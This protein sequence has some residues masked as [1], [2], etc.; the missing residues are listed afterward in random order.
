MSDELVE[1]FKKQRPLY[2]A[3]TLSITSLLGQLLS[4]QGIS[5]FSVES[6][7][8]DIESFSRKVTREDKVDKYIILSNITDLSGIRI[9]CY[10]QQDC[11]DIEN[12]INESF[13]VDIENSTSKTNEIDADK[14]GYLSDHYVISITN[15]RAQ[16]PEFARFRSMKAE[17]QV[18]TVL[19]HTW[20]AIDHKLRYKNDANIPRA[21][22]RRLFRISALLESA[23][24]EFSFLNEK[25]ESLR[26]EYSMDIEQGKLNIPINADSVLA[27]LKSSSLIDKMRHIVGHS[28][29]F[30]D[31]DKSLRAD[32]VIDVANKLGVEGVDD[33]VARANRGLLEVSRKWGKLEAA[34]K[35][36]NRIAT[37]TSLL[38]LAVVLGSDEQVRKELLGD[39]NSPAVS[40]FG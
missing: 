37:R 28:D 18:R 8:K 29:R 36:K 3:F 40:V 30:I 15:D 24:D 22:R 19:Q 20:A 17:I 38:R 9:I 23:D 39:E 25:V 31:E 1:A 26:S 16:M 2:E 4:D 12:L 35:L 7:T 14:F 21:I 6:R 34:Y 32:I 13:E 33:L 11:K 5:V 27:L 10:L